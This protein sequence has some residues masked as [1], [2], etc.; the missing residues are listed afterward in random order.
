[1]DYCFKFRWA[2]WNGMYRDDVRRF[3]KGMKGSFAT[4]VAGSSDL[5]QVNQRKPPYRG[6]NFIIAHDGFTLRDHTILRGNW[7]MKNFHLALMISQIDNWDNPESKL[8][9]SVS[10]QDVYAAFNP[11]DYFV[12][13]EKTMADTNMESP[14]D[15]VKEGVSETYN[16][17]PFSSIPLK[18]M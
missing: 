1:M 7:Q 13:V 8:H 10:G 9:D 16:V 4:R 3:I 14:D 15:F 2:E 18:S 11:H 12:T 17:A 5:Y 6:V